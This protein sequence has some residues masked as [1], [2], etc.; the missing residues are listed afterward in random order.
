MNTN[1]NTLKDNTKG[2]QS[3]GGVGIVV[4]LIL[5]ML[6]FL[7][8]VP[9]M[10]TPR[11]LGNGDYY[12]PDGGSVEAMGLG[13]IVFMVSI[14]MLFYPWLKMFGSMVMEHPRERYYG[15][16]IASTTFCKI[17]S[18]ALLVINAL[19]VI[20]LTVTSTMVAYNISHWDYNQ[21]LCPDDSAFFVLL[22]IGII[23][24]WGFINLVYGISHSIIK[25]KERRDSAKMGNF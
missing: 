18:V 6:L 13:L 5:I 24:F 23:L 10:L 17:I 19:T 2:T 3:V 22:W 15:L 7:S 8:F 14:F 4:I 1:M 21:G 20:L 11:S 12:D 16:F 9:I 25:R